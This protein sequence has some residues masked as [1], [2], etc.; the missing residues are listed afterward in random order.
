MADFFE[1]IAQNTI[2]GQSCILSVATATYTGTLAQ[3]EDFNANHSFRQTPFKPAG[4]A[5]ARVVL[6][7]EEIVQITINVNAGL[8]FTWATAYNHL[9][10]KQITDLQFTDY[11]SYN[12]LVARYGLIY[13]V[14][15]GKAQGSSQQ[16]VPVTL[17]AGVATA[18][19]TQM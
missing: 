17:I 15:L 2:L 8:N 10:G 4:S 9:Y 7:C 19:Y 6:E 1:S 12:S 14:G 18:G 11:L 3:Y 13:C 5:I 16:I